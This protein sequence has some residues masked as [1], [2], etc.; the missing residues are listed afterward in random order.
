MHDVQGL[1]D[2]LLAEQK[3]ASD[4]LDRAIRDVQAAE[5]VLALL[6]GDTEGD[7]VVGPTH[8]TT[9]PADIAQCR[10]Q[11]DA[12]EKMARANGGMLHVTPASKVI[13]AAGLSEAKI[14]SITATLHNRVSASDEWEYAEPGT[15]RLVAPKQAGDSLKRTTS[16]MEIAIIEDDERLRNGHSS[17]AA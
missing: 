12:A 11:M 7:A 10:T 14:S 3:E 9:T 16:Q 17:P 13:R 15:F 1:L 5:R 6:E 8:G 4:R 2:R